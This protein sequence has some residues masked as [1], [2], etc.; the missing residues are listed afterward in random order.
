MN[1]G[2]L[3]AFRNYIDYATTPKSFKKLRLKELGGLNTYLR[4]ITSTLGE[5]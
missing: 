2:K 1:S 4:Q 5:K 3:G